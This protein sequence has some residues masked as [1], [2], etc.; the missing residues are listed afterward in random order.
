M[1]GASAGALVPSAPE[2][3]HTPSWQLVR[4]QPSPPTL[5]DSDAITVGAPRARPP[6]SNPDLGDPPPQ[7]WWLLR[8]WAHQVRPW[9]RS[10]ELDRRAGGRPPSPS[11]L[12]GTPVWYQQIKPQARGCHDPRKQVLGPQRR[13]AGKL[14]VACKL[15]VRGRGAPPWFIRQNSRGRP[16][17]I[18]PASRQQSRLCPCG[19][20][21]P[22][23]SFV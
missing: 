3:C 20:T 9:R 1:S 17:P 21:S 11:A 13:T 10:S 6:V 14:T 4:N 8:P 16:Q 12:A 19:S 23:L 7:H 2:D 18:P 22:A 15:R 5:C